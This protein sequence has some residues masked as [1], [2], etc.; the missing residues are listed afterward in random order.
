MKNPALLLLISSLCLAQAQTTTEAPRTSSVAREGKVLTSKTQGMDAP[1]SNELNCAGFIIHDS[2]KSDVHVVGSLTSPEETHF[3]QSEIIYLHGPE[4]KEG[5]VLSLLRPVQDPNKFEAFPRQRAMVGR[6]GHPYAEI[7]RVKV[8]AMRGDIAVADVQLSC[9]TILP[10]DMA[11]RFREKQSPKFRNAKFDMFAPPNGKTTGRIV[12]AKDFDTYLST[13]NVVYLNVGSDEGIKVGDYLRTARSPKE[14]NA[15]PAQSLSDKAD[16]TDDEQKGGYKYSLRKHAKDLPRHSNGEMMVIGVTPRT[17]T[18]IIT[19]ALADIHVGDD[20]ELEEERPESSS[21]IASTAPSSSENPASS[22]NGAANPAPETSP[23]GA[24]GAGQ[25]PVI[26]CSANPATVRV[27]ETSNISCN[28]SSPMERAVTVKFGAASAGQLT[29]RLN[30]A[31]LDTTGVSPGPIV[32]N[33]AAS[34]DAGLSASTS[35]TVTVEAAPQVAVA[36][37]LTELQFKPR[38]AYVNNEAKAVLDD[39]ALLLQHQPTANALVVG[40]T[41]P[42][43]DAQL[44]Q[45]RAVNASNYL[46]KSKGIDPSRI[47]T[48]P[49]A[50]ADGN[51]AE[52][53]LI[54]AG[55]QAPQQ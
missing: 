55:A 48:R 54:P 37:K 46:I 6:L 33:A 15:D 35:T 3:S 39:V 11:V 47:Q 17:S 9:T 5:D 30:H 41:A 32:V 27:G 49:A 2:I 38:S 52:V 8:R 1:S 40:S 20:V 7:G 53:W 18:A 42:N 14:V 4:L 26:Y 44:R 10:G 51:K 34:D 36:S 22:A 45:Q 43:E 25:Q 23:N 31:T 29:S 50:Q 16:I 28:A 12:M 21:A 19:L 13:G 24:A